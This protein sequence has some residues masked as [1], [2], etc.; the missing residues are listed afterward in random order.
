MSTNFIH[1]SKFWNTVLKASSPPRMYGADNAGSFFDPEV[2]Q[3]NVG[4]LGTILTEVVNHSIEGVDTPFLY[5]GMWGSLFCWHTEDMEL[6]SIN[7]LHCGEPKFWYAIPLHQSK[8]FESLASEVFPT[9]AKHCDNFIRHKS[10]LISPDVLQNRGLTVNKIAQE[11]GQFIITF[12]RGYHAGFNCG[13]NVAESINFA[14]VRWIDH[15]ENAVLCSCQGDNIVR[16][17][18]EEFT[19]YKPVCDTEKNGS[20]MKQTTKRKSGT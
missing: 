12:P 16:L 11:C 19:K 9:A 4:K 8:Q 14:T 2:D 17:N 1:L 20:R 15:G 3:W 18:M 13:F 5:V 10:V 7:Y 6:Y